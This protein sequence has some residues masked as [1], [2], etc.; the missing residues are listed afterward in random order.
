[1]IRPSFTASRALVPGRVHVAPRV[2]PRRAGSRTLRSLAGTVAGACLAALTLTAL[3]ATAA[4]S[5]D[6]AGATTAASCSAGYVALTFDDGPTSATTTRLIEILRS[7]DAIATVFPTGQNIQNNTAGLRAYDDAGLVVGNH[8]WSHPHLTSMSSADIRSQLERSQQIIQQTIGKTPTLFRPPYG[9][10]N[11]TVRSIESSLGLTEV[12]WSVDTQDYNNLSS[13]QVRQRA[14]AAQAGAVVL[15]HD[16]PTATLDALPGIISDL[17][18]RNLCP[19]VIS[20][21]TGRAVAPSTTTT[22]TNPTDPTT[23]TDPGTGPACT[24]TYSE[25][26][27]WNDRFNGTVT[28]RANRAITSWTSTVTVRSPQ[29]IISTWN[30]TPSWDSSGTVLTMRPAGNGTLAAGQTTSFGFTVQHGGQ[31]AWPAVACS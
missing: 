7:N 25:G 13:S 29:R 27:K 11:A 20:P 19:G 9:E 6:L 3:P 21:S 16:W 4:V 24:A 15:M 12:L 26:Q 28:I 1:M 5:T 23:P 18:A 8:S 22:P 14:A 31:W 17:R 10:S 2:R 30:G